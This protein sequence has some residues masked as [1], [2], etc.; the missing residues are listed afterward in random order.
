[1][2]PRQQFLLLFI[3]SIK[4]SFCKKL[5]L[6]CCSLS[7]AST[8]RKDI[9][10]FSHLPYL[11]SP[12]EIIV[13]KSYKRLKTPQIYNFFSGS[14]LFLAHFQ[15]LTICLKS[16]AISSCW[17]GLYGVWKC[18]SQMSPVSP[19]RH[20]YFLTFQVTWLPCDLNSLICS[21]KVINLQF[22]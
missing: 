8:T 22:V 9:S 2:C 4:V 11:W 14:T 15:H 7:P 21:K 5:G 13:R 19:R 10:G 18:L 6:G 12:D 20:L 17:L 16:F 3:M 1:M